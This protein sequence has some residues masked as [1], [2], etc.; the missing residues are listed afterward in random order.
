M[1]RIKRPTRS[2]LETFQT[3]LS[4]VESAELK[5][6]LER[7]QPTVVRESE[8]YDAAAAAGQFHTLARAKLI[9][10]CVTTEEL[11]ELYSKHLAQQSSAGRGIYDELKAAAPN[12]RCPLC[13]QGFVSTLD[14]FLPK[15]YYPGLSVAPLNLVPACTDCNRLKGRRYPRSAQEATL[16]PYFDNVEEDSWLGARVLEENPAAALFLVKTVPGWDEVTQ[17]RVKRHFK[18]LHLSRLYT[19]NASDEISNIRENLQRVFV[20]GGGE[21][22]REYLQE[23]ARS[24]VCA[25]VNS[26][27]SALYGALAESEWYWGGGFDL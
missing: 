1:W 17:A 27:Q 13:G 12:G 10:G 18:T 20:A 25:R 23:A 6:R 8:L 5:A 4:G 7:I 26:W 21:A 15:F 22:V 11:S 3:C 2:V 19:A 14:H 9:D 16:H 24:R